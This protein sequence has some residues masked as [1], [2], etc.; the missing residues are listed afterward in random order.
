MFFSDLYYVVY[1]KIIYVFNLKW[2]VYENKIIVYVASLS[3]CV[4]RMG[5]K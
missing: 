2:K 1:S 3:L 5:A 4:Y